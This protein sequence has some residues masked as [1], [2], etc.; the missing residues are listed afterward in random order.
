MPEYRIEPLIMRPGDG[1]K[2]IIDKA[3]TLLPE[4]DSPN[5]P[6]ASPVFTEKDIFFKASTSLPFVGNLTLK[7]MTL[8]IAFSI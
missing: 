2:F 5:I 7:S 1:T 6:S 4:P 8:R 3:L